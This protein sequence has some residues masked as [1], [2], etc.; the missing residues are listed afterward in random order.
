MIVGVVIELAVGLLCIVLGLLLWKKQK[1]SLLHDYHYQ[2]V[3]REDIPAYTRRVGMGIVIVGAGIA[4]A[5][6][7]DLA[8]SP[9]WWTPLAAGI[10]PGLVLIILAQRKYNRQK[11]TEE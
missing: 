1:I 6:L 5:G 4:A 11:P 3:K 2:Y 8:L 9:L 7:L 10:V